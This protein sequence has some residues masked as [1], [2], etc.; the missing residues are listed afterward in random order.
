MREAPWI[1][2]KGKLACT[3]YLHEYRQTYRWG[4][5][6]LLKFRISILRFSLK[7]IKNFLSKLILWSKLSSASMIWWRVN[8]RYNQRSCIRSIRY[9]IQNRMGTASIVRTLELWSHPFGWPQNTIELRR[10]NDLTVVHALEIAYTNPSPVYRDISPTERGGENEWN[11]F[12]W[13]GRE[14]K[15]SGGS[16][17]DAQRW[18]TKYKKTKCRF[19]TNLQRLVLLFRWSMPGFF[20]AFSGLSNFNYR[21][22][23]LSWCF[24]WRFPYL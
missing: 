17:R 16:S 11:S 24:N 22:H 4:R 6:N 2:C 18:T 15:E 3:V 19:S 14:K 13:S 20:T 21:I 23:N 5:N 9:S 12:G 10:G 8:C 7:K 1:Y